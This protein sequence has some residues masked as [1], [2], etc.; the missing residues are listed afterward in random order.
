MAAQRSEMPQA[1]QQAIQGQGR[2]LW[3]RERES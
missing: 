3:R 1:H 2:T